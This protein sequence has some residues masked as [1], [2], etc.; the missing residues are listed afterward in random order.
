MRSKG[1]RDRKGEL[2][3]YLEGDRL[4]TMDGEITGRLQGSYIVDM[5]GNRIWRIY[6]DGVYSLDSLGAIGYFGPDAPDD[7]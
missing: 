4:F 6:D 2:F 3:A 5:A 7:S 1:L